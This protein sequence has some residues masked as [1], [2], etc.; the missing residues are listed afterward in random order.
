MLVRFNNEVLRH[1]VSATEPRNL[2]LEW[3]EL[4]AK[5]AQIY[6]E[7]RTDRR[8]VLLALVASWTLA[9]FSSAAPQMKERQELRQLEAWVHD[10]ALQVLEERAHRASASFP[11]AR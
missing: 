8:Y 10:Y 1:G 9:R 3:L 11:Q 4:L 5:E 7:D 6:F 2:S